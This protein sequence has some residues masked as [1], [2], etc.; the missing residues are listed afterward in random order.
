MQPEDQCPEDLYPEEAVMNH[1]VCIHGDT[2]YADIIT[3]A[4]FDRA[5]NCVSVEDAIE[6]AAYLRNVYD[7]DEET[8]KIA[9]TVS[10]LAMFRGW[11]VQYGLGRADQMLEATVLFDALMLDRETASSGEPTFRHIHLGLLTDP[12]HVEDIRTFSPFVKRWAM[13]RAEDK[14]R[15]FGDVMKPDAREYLEKVAKGEF[16]DWIRFEGDE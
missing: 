2:P 10:A 4:W 16:P 8:A 7:L 14:L 5:Y 15:R 12:G 11:A 1:P 3:E 13:A 6:V 9:S